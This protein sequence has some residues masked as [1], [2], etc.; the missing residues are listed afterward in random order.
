MGLASIKMHN[1]SAV[2]FNHP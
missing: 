1:N 2:V